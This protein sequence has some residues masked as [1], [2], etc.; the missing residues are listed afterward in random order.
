M[1]DEST[2]LAHK[3][4]FGSIYRCAHGCIHVQTGATTVTMSEKQYLEFVAMVA[5]SG[6][7]YEL[8]RDHGYDADP[9]LQ[10]SAQVH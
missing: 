7:M 10:E 2:L 5:E 6:S 8:F 3:R 9:D 4:G 1:A